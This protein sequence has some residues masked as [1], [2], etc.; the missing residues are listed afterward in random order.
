MEILRNQFVMRS[1]KAPRE[2]LT[3]KS[4][5]ESTEKCRVNSI[6]SSTFHFYSFHQAFVL[7]IAGSLKSLL[8]LFDAKLFIRQLSSRTL[9]PN[10]YA[11]SLLSLNLTHRGSLREVWVKVL[12]KR[13]RRACRNIRYCAAFSFEEGRDVINVALVYFI[14]H[15][16]FHRSFSFFLLP[17]LRFLRKRPHFSSD[18]F[19]KASFVCH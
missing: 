19:N 11:S 4:M 6:N 14:A 15:V 13:K 18:S 5:Q 9:R 10:V 16:S 3:C 1:R 12:E 17:Y 2:P 8:R 7:R